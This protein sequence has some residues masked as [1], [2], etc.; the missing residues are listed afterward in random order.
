[1]EYSGVLAALL[2]AAAMAPFATLAAA[3]PES[4]ERAYF[5][6]VVLVNQFG[7]PMRFYTDL[8][9]GK[10]VVINTFFTSCD[11]ACP[12]M[13]GGLLEIQDWLGDRLGRDAHLI[14]ISV[15]PEIDTPARLR[16]YADR[17]KARPGW[18]FL[19]GEPENVD[20]VLSR[21]GQRV[22]EREAHSNILFIGNEPAKKWIKVFGL[23]PPQKL[24]GAI[25]S[26]QGGAE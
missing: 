3:Q 25:E 18:F 19:T 14:S 11:G 7:E 9:E 24:I 2:L 4:P 12:V 1:M 16:E 10:T 23:D 13:S 15:D 17:F 5:T 6:D 8:L 20:W 26:V 21:L 22:Q